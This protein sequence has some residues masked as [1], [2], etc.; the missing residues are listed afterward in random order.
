[1]RDGEAV[2]H[3]VQEGRQPAG[4]RQLDE[5]TR[6]YTLRRGAGHRA[7]ERLAIPLP[8]LQK[9]W[10]SFPHTLLPHSASGGDPDVLP[11]AG[12]RP[13]ADDRR[14]RSVPHRSDLQR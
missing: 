10:R 1:M 7:R 6:L 9:R 14:A 8:L 5:Q 4:A 12:P 3:R 2:Q 13:N 11:G